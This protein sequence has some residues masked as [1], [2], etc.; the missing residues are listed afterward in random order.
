MRPVLFVTA[1]VA[2]AAATA[3]V[4]AAS[5]YEMRVDA[6]ARARDTSENLC[7][8]L[9]RDIE[10]NFE[11]YELL[12][13]NVA[14][15]ANRPDVLHL[16]PELRQRVLFNEQMNARDMGV[17][18]VTDA[19]GNVVIDS[20]AV[21]PQ[22]FDL[23]HRDYF[24]VQ[25]QSDT[26][27]LYFSKPFVSLRDGHPM[28]VAM[29]RRVD[30]DGRFAGI[31]VG[32]F[33]L[34]YFQRLLSDVTLG[35][36]GS[37]TLLRF[38]GTVLMRRPYYEAEIGRNI[39]GTESFAPLLLSD[40]GSFLGRA[41]LDGERRLYSFRH[42]GQYPLIVVVGLSL[43]DIYAEWTRRAWTIG[44]GMAALDVLLILGAVLFAHQYRKRITAEQQLQRLA[45]TDG[46]TGLGTRRM[47][48]ATLDIEWRRAQRCH[49]PL[50]I[51]MIDVDHFKNY[52][53][54]YGHIAGDDVLRVVARCIK[55]SLRR[56]GDFAG[57]YGGEEFCV[58]LPNTDLQGAIQVAET[59]R[60]A[61]LAQ[62]LPHAASPDG[63]LSVSIGVGAF[64]GAEVSQST[65]EAL[66]DRVDQRLYEAKT[67][68]RNR[69]RPEAVL[70]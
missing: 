52:N 31:V 46:L 12:I 65:I 59:I 69:V 63:V 54:S 13:Q 27:G 47:L 5:L 15:N 16:P 20:R 29:S 53:D 4:V 38:D 14:D 40:H 1:G 37:I 49:Q 42:I 67:A 28:S 7:I 33:R 2:I 66:V 45:D 60:G 26:A 44:G 6:F 25:Q 48:D 32:A 30:D 18:L 41:A 55:D 70:L 43:D 57:R 10:R 36:H 23:S 61:I 50:S 9:Q 62:N 3:L 35:N 51:L 8:I 68:G 17:I 56:P 58:L 64:D 19:H 24:Q 11:I 22:P 39:S 21:P 34:S